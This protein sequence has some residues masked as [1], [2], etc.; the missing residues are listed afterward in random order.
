M[1]LDHIGYA[2]GQRV[3]AFGPPHM[4]FGMEVTRTL[5]PSMQVLLPC[6]INDPARPGLK[7]TPF[8]FL[9]ERQIPAAELRTE[10]ARHLRDDAD[11]LVVHSAPGWS[12]HLAR[13][14]RLPHRRHLTDLLAQWFEPA[15]RAVVAVSVNADGLLDARDTGRFRTVN[16]L[17]MSPAEF[18]R[19]LAAAD[20]VLSDN[21]ISVSIGR[22]VALDRCCALLANSRS[23]SQ[24]DGSEAAGARVARLIERQRPGAVFPWEVFPI[25]TADDL[26]LLGFGPDHAFRRC[27]ARLETFDVD[28]TQAVLA[29]LLDGGARASALAATRRSYIGQVAQLPAP[30]AALAGVLA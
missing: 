8:R 29:E 14:L 23:I 4:T 17:P 22:A 16:L 12:V 24:F 26:D 19:L 7:G 27:I 1:T 18:E 6:P 10:R 11:V 5:P 28:A 3:V 13:E 30:A 15:K 20:I 25:W 2:Q 21:A 9:S